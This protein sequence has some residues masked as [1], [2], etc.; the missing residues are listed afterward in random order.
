MATDLPTVFL[1]QLIAIGESLDFSGLGQLFAEVAP[2]GCWGLRIFDFPPHKLRHLLAKSL[3]DGE[4]EALIRALT[5][6]E[7]DIPGFGAGSVSSIIWAFHC[8]E[9]RKQCRPDVL[10]DWVLANTTNPYVPF[11]HYNTSGARSVA[12]WDA[13][14]QLRAERRVACIRQ[15]K[16]RKTMAAAGKAEKAT[17]NIFPAIRRKDTKAVEALVLHGARLDAPNAK[18]VTALAYAQSLGHAPILELLQKISN[19]REPID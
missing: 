8:L 1:R 5:V 4:L 12:E 3:S 13:Y 14:V 15:E 16:E 6:A 10:A 18:G 2:N 17:K 7:R 9:Q 11:G 19:G